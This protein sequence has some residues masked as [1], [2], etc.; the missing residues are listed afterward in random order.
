MHVRAAKSLFDVIMHKVYCFFLCVCVCVLQRVRNPV[1][2][3]LVPSLVSCY[4]KFFI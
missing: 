2:A 3:H 1:E 4:D